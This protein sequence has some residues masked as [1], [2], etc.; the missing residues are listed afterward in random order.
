MAPGAIGMAPGAIGMAPGATETVLVAPSRPAIARLALP[1]GPGPPSRSSMV[2]VPPSPPASTT[3][4]RSRPSADACGA[5]Q[6]ASSG[7]AAPGSPSAPASASTAATALANRAAGSAAVARA[8][9]ASIP[10]GS[11]TPRRAARAVA[12]STGPED[13]ASAK[14]IGSWLRCR[15]VL[16]VSAPDEQREG[17]HPQ[18]M[19]VGG[20]RELAAA[21]L[22]RRHVDRRARRG[23][24]LEAGAGV[25]DLGDAEI[26][27]LEAGRL[28]LAP[29]Q[30]EVAGLQ[31]AMDD[32]EA[33]HLVEPER[34]LPEPA[35]RLGGRTAPLAREPLGQRLALQELHHEEGRRRRPVDP[36]VDD[37]DEERAVDP[38]RDRAPPAR[39]AAGDRRA[40]SCAR[41]SP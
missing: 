30:E 40:R 7:S 31:V 20:R 5:D 12:G 1:D 25:E 27:D 18:R 11:E 17:D 15:L 9:H 38:A 10:G 22:L 36:R 2:L 32:P 29:L 24:R 13:A 26:E 14:A 3:G 16:P 34:R 4:A 33:V 19:D 37:V 6:V 21:E 41:A 8:N 23:R 28:V 35:E 39:T